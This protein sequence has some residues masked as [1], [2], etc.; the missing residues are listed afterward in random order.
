MGSY[1]SQ[2]DPGNVPAA[3]EAPKSNIAPVN[4]QNIEIDAKRN[5]IKDEDTTIHQ[6][7]SNKNG[8]VAHCEIEV[9]KDV[10]NIIQF[11]KNKES[12]LFILDLGELVKRV[13]IWK[14]YLPRVQPYYAVKC[15]SYDQVIKTLNE[16]GVNFDCASKNEIDSVVKHGVSADRIVYSNTNKEQNHLKHAFS[17]GVDLMVFDNQDELKKIKAHHPKARLLLRIRCNATSCE[18]DMG[19]K[20]GVE[21]DDVR[22]L[23]L[24]AGRLKLKVVG[25][26]FHVGSDCTDED[27]FPEAIKYSHAVFE[28]AKTLGICM[29][30]LDI[31]GGFTTDAKV[32]FRSITVGVNK[33]LDKYFPASAKVKIIAE[34]GR[35]MVSSAFT[36]AAKVIGKKLIAKSMFYHYYINDGIYGAFDVKFHSTS[37]VKVIP[38]KGNV[39]KEY[40][41]CI[42]GQTCAP[43]DKVADFCRLP[44]L[45]L[46]DWLVFPNMGAYTLS[47]ATMFNGFLPAK[48]YLLKNTW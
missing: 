45:F 39:G 3:L 10:L 18:C 47:T 12:S 23:L 40:P 34:P 29:N 9:S 2:V 27:A 21:I 20:F 25:V 46:G 31:G 48:V 15:N 19:E 4:Q 28:I 26:S 8:N 24:L 32:N 11:H 33:A 36:L 43:E 7:N 44:E 37:N 14:A 41:C 17:T 5:I 42:W 22:S 38:M 30:I 6:D 13:K 1:C 16:L 35:Y